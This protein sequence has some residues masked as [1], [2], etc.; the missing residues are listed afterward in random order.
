MVYDTSRDIADKVFFVNF[1]FNSSEIV[2]FVAESVKVQ[3]VFAVI[4][5]G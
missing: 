4:R 5:G 3:L 2:N 1:Y